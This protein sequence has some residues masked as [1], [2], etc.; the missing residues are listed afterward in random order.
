MSTFCIPDTTDWACAF[1]DEQ[2]ADMRANSADKMH[3]SEAL[4]WTSLARLCGYQ[5]GVCPE[6]VRP[7]SA[8]CASSSLT[9]MQATVDSGHTGALPA[10]TIGRS[11]TPYVTGGNWVNGCGC[12]SGSS[13]DCVELESVYLPGPVGDIVSV[14]LDGVI[15]SPAF[16]RVDNGTQLVNL[17]PGTPWPTCQPANAAPNEGLVVNYYR[18]AAPNELTNY[19][20]GVLAAEFFKACTGDKKCRLPSGT[21]S[22]V[23]GG[24]TIEL[25]PDL[26]AALKRIPEVGAVVAIYNPHSLAGPLRVL[27]PDVRNT[28]QPTWRSY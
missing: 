17:D 10:R 27:S 13:C 26:T 24:T 16:Y 22:V 14:K 4:A 6:E 21:I 19:A 8:R 1:S 7:C 25:E 9:W 28:R 3:R 2:L 11:F 20:A 12:S 23:R 15:L 5:I 18:G